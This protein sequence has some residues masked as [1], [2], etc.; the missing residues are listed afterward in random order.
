VSRGLGGAGDGDER[1]EVTAAALEGEENTHGAIAFYIACHHVS[2]SSL[3][4]HID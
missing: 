3:F 4:S 2:A 1:I